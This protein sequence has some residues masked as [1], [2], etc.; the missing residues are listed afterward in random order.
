MAIYLN[1]SENICQRPFLFERHLAF[2]VIIY[3]NYFRI[4]Q[5]CSAYWGNSA[6]PFGSHSNNSL[7]IGRSCAEFINFD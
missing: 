4:F 5:A 1:S 7:L 6:F 3:A 2:V